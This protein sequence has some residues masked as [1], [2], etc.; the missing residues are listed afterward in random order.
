MRKL[1]FK[2]PDPESLY[3]CDTRRVAKLRN[4]S[5][6]V[7]SVKQC[8]QLCFFLLDLVDG[9]LLGR[10]VRT[11]AQQSGAMSKALAGEVIVADFNHEFWLKRHP[12]GGTLGHP[13]ARTARRIAG[14]ARRTHQRL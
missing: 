6:T 9:A 10:L 7:R 4:A 13:A 1:V 5:K 11:P 2:A 14:E 8:H 12:F 3:D